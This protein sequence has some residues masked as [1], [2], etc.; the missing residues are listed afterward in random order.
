MMGQDALNSMETEM[1][2]MTKGQDTATD[3]SALLR[4]RN[5]LLWVVTREEARVEAFLFEAASAAGYISHTWDCAMGVADMQGN[6][7]TI[8]GV[9]P[10]ETLNAIRDRAR[11]ADRGVWI[12]R[13]LAPWLA[14]PIGIQTIRTMRNLARFLPSVPRPNAQAIIVLTP[15]SDIPP[16][17]A[18][19]AT[20]IEWPMPDRAEIAS[21]LDILIEQYELSDMLKNGLRDSAIDAAVGLSSEEAKA[22]YARSLVQLKRIDPATVAKEKKRVI[23]RERVLEWFDPIPGGL[24]AVGGL[25]NLKA[26]LIGR[27][28]AYSPQAREYGLPCPKGALLVGV[29]GCGKSLLAKAIST[30]WSVPLLRLDLGALKSKFVGE[31]EGNL[32]RAF[33]VIESV[34]RCV[35]WIDEIEKALAGA[36]QGAADGGVSSD[37]LGSILSWMQERQGEAFVIA[38]ANDVEGL[39]PELLRKGRFDEVWFVDL[40]NATERTAVLNAALMPYRKNI[41]KQIGIDLVGVSDVTEGFT[42]SEISALVPDALFAAFNDGA[43]EITTD[44]LISAASTVVPLSKTAAEKIGKLRDWARNRARP[45][46]SIETAKTSKSKIGLVEID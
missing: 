29:P 12:M 45:A 36:T 9:D 18:G 16:E 40:P 4:A 8:G 10:V 7:E 11:R 19:H 28:S 14:G 2:K 3:I 42:G 46:T 20:V 44:D 23:A 39:P 25:D 22:C 24:D 31:S 32:R 15:S 26:W 41:D 35:V 33:R 37:A 13:D 38:T 1:T 34:G 17:L 27:S 21:I 6:P 30:A 5:P 43:R